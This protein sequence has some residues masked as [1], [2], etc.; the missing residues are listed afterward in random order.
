MSDTTLHIG[1]RRLTVSHMDKVFFPD[2]GLTK[3]DVV[4]YYRR[5]ADTMLPH[6]RDRPL[7]LQRFP[8][9]IGEEG[10]Y[11]KDAPD[12]FPVWIRRVEVEVKEDKA[13]QPQVVCDDAASLVY[14][15]SQACLTLHPWLSRADA[16]DRPDKLIFDLD[17]PDDDFG[18]VRAAA[19][20]LRGLLDD[21]GLVP[22][23]MTTGSRGLHVAVPLDRQAEFD[24]VRAF[25]HDLAAL[26]ARREPKRFT[27]ATRKAE[28]KGRL[29]LDYLR[30][31]YGQT[32]VAPY[33]LRAK[34]GAPVATPLDWDELDDASLR[35]QTY[36]L[37]NIFRR[38][39][40]KDDPWRQMMRHRRSLDDPRQRLD[41]WLAEERS[42]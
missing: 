12:Y 32:A 22:Y 24:D 25:A 28:R 40:Q 19:R 18:P 41:G 23:L 9:G 15:A 26:L 17:P 21:V 16:L 6:L 20:A 5:L 36:T 13:T 14:L 4:E 11:Q 33:A 8:D 1:R 31:A 37:G 38:L 10:F 29:F 30:N 27:V 39:G 3:G 2:A 35:S 34:P 42:G 7:S